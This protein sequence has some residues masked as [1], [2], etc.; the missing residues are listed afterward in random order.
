MEEE[1]IIALREITNPNWVELVMLIVTT[2]YFAATCL[3]LRANRKTA[4][5]AKKQFEALSQPNVIVGLKRVDS[6]LYLCVRN[7]GNSAAENVAIH[8]SR[9]SEWCEALKEIGDKHE[10][11][12][13][14]LVSLGGIQFTLMPKQEVGFTICICNSNAFDLFKSLKHIEISGKYKWRGEEQSIPPG[15]YSLEMYND[16]MVEF[17]SIDSIT[18]SI[19][20]L[21]NTVSTELS[22]MKSLGGRC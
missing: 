4:D 11:I 3:I 7:D 22:S 6:I 17:H 2:G 20:G 9:V 21:A 12:A 10:A 13:D 16:L 5:I 18:E 19:N 14:Y 15:S 1:I 8:I